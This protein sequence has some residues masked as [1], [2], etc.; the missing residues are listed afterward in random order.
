MGVT[1]ISGNIYLDVNVFIY[2][3]E[4][5]DEFA[6]V[7]SHL[8]DYIDKGSLQAFTRYPFDIAG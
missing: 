3:L 7:L 2:L 1:H 4:G 6:A 8:V 5:Y